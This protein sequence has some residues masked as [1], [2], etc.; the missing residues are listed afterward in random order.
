MTAFSRRQRKL[1]A[2]QHCRGIAKGCVAWGFLL[3]VVG[4]APGSPALMARTCNEEGLLA[5]GRVAAGKGERCLSDVA[6]RSHAA[7]GAS[8][9]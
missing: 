6:A 8:P 1:D 3:P 4:A 7:T 5:D 9:G 2:P